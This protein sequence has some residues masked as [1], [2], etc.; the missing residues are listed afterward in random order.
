MKFG[1]YFAYWEK[2]WEADYHKYIEKVAGLGFDILEVGAGSLEA[3]EPGQLYELKRAAK[4]AGISLTACIGLP[5]EYNVSSADEAVRSHGVEYMKSICRKLEMAGVQAVGGIIYAYWPCDYAQPVD[6]PAAR[7]QSIRSMREIAPVARDCGVTLMLET[8]NRFE[9]FIIN[10]AAEA[11]QF[12]EDIGEE[13]VKVMLDSFHMN[14]EEDDMGDAIRTAGDHLGHFHIGEANRKVP[15]KGHMDWDSIGRG[16][17][18]IHYE[19]AV[20]MEPFVCM[21][22]TVGKDIKVW[23]DMSSH[24]DEKMLDREIAEALKF[25]KNKFLG[26]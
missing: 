7:A 6:K 8:V 13:N 22:G 25:V 15:G 26:A 5:A 23:R 20:V 21:G 9:Q 11:V 19:G 16:L 24:A 2:E 18:D 1:T 10:D 3:M 12:A 17:R 14:I 4:D